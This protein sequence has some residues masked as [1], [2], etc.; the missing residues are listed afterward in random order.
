VPVGVLDG[1]LG[2]ADPAEAVQGGDRHR[3]AGGQAGP[4]PGQQVP[5]AGEAPVPRG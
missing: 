2:F 3:G 5:A 4:Q 1:Q